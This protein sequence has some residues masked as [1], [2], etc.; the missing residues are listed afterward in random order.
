MKQANLTLK[1]FAGR[2]FTL[3]T[4]TAESG[5]RP[6]MIVVPGGSFDHLSKKESTPVALAYYEAGFNTA[7]VE[8]NLIT[9][10]GMIYPDAALDVLTT[11]KFYRDHADE[12][13]TFTDEIVTLGFSAGGHVTTTAN[14]FA[15]SPIYQAEYGYDKDEVLPNK[16]ILGYPLID[17]K[18]IGFPMPE[19]RD[20]L[21]PADPKI[22][23]TA[24]AVTRET[25]A[26]FI[27][28]ALDDRI[29]LVENSISYL[30][31][32]REAEVPAELHLFETGGHGF[33][34]ANYHEHGWPNDEH[35]ASWFKLS[36]TWLGM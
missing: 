19:G 6:V 8:Y 30:Q 23:D 4:Y 32:L 33:G 26:S 16:T 12:Y 14:Y 11:V 2:E 18:K 7:I 5:K 28:Q 15:V 1:N 35:L 24:L 36:L 31:A 10:P 17:I 34:L 20:D 29:V 13:G 21:L 25:P 9:D 22:D 3:R 27:F